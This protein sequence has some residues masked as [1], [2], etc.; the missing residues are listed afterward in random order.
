VTRAREKI[1]SEPIDHALESENQHVPFLQLPGTLVLR[2]SRSKTKTMAVYRHVAPIK[3]VRPSVH[4][5]S[6]A[7]HSEPWLTP[8]LAL[9][10]SGNH[11][12]PEALD[13]K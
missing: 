12:S 5:S 6:M 1:H 2:L 3:I 7:P 8:Q 9:E 4:V 10:L 13:P 11:G